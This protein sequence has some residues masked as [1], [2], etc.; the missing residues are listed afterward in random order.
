MNPL[1]HAGRAPP[2]HRLPR[3]IA[4]FLAT[5]LAAR[6]LGLAC[7]LVQVPIVIRSLGSE[8]FGLWMAMAGLSNLVLFADLGL[9]IGT[10][11]RLAEHFARDERS[12]ARGLLGSVFL[13]LAVL[14]AAL[15]VLFT[16]MVSRTDL[17]AAFH[18]QDAATIAEAP[19]AVLAFAWFFCAGFPLG[20]AQ[21]VAF[22]HQEG[23]Q[24]N[25]AQGAGSLLSLVAIAAGAAAHWRLAGLVAAAQG[26]ILLGN[27]GLLATQLTRLQWWHRWHLRPRAA[28]LR[29]LLRR[30]VFFAVQQ[31]L[32]TVLFS[33]PPVVVATSLGAA[34]VTPLNLVQ[35]LF[36]LFAVIQN[37]FM[38]PLWP[39]Y[40]EAKARR[41]F[42]W[43]RR[44]LRRSLQATAVCSVLPM[45]AGAAFAPMLIRLWVGPAAP[46]PDYLLVGLLY[47]WNA[48]VFIQQPFSF[49]LAGVSEVRRTTA[50]SVL[51]A[52]SCG[53][54]MYGL[55]RPFGTNGVILGLLLGYVPFTFLG[56][57][58]ETRRYLQAAPRAVDAAPVPTI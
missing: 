17:T 1:T 22:A 38:L 14:G 43:M 35:R 8:A 23:W 16:V 42:G 29:E 10:Q 31:L 37:A 34:A 7:Q 48:L 47:A 5:S 57:V 2:V 44:T 18:L 11:N 30:G 4:R 54:L 56:N 51:S 53:L 27:V 6:S 41:E 13:V 46:A 52:A 28:P 40:S 50:Y 25:V 55:A 24:Y 26:A 58:L 21:R 20:L 3:R 39:A 9:G 49:L 19:S 12:A 15:A 33:L 36:N 32:T 45:L